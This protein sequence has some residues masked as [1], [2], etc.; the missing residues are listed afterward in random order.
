MLKRTENKTDKKN[1]AGGAFLWGFILGAIFA[2]LLTT[3]KGRAIL[4]ELVN[5]GV[6]MIEDFV[7]DR[8]NKAYEKKMDEREKIII[9]EEK[10]E[11]KNAKED[12]ESKVGETETVVQESAKPKEEVI[13]EEVSPEAFN[14]AKKMDQT[15]TTL[16]EISSTPI[17]EPKKRGSKRRLF[18]GI[19]RGKA[20]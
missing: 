20:N 1:H 15:E 8:K 3:K 16:E 5:T 18:R 10:E 6:E 11:V 19:R 17:P 7:E 4:K 12:L 13:V 14:F 9:Q 2:S